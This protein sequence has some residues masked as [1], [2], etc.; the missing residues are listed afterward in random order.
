MVGW[1]ENGVLK[2]EELGYNATVILPA[3]HDTASAV[4]AAPINEQS[5]YISSGNLVASRH[6]TRKGA[7]G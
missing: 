7:C 3:T 2:T 4:L 5:P 6:R 1:L